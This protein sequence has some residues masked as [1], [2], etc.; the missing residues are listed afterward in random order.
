MKGQPRQNSEREYRTFNVTSLGVE[1]RTE[2]DRQKIVGHAA[3]FDTIGDGGWFREK[4]APGAF[5]LSIENDDIR[6]LFNHD[7]NFVL[8][9]NKAG[10]LEL[11]E[12]DK[13]LWVGIDPPDTQ[14]A[15]DLVKSIGR[16]DITQ[17]S[18]GFEILKEERVS[19]EGKDP[20][21]FILKEVRLWDVSPVTFPFYKQT[22]VSVHSR[23][24]WADAQNAARSFES[25][26]WK[27][28]L[29]RKKLD[30]T[31]RRI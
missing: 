2:G 31:Q 3:V 18:F 17:M 11:R 7:P 16:G 19:G 5:T 29:L 24:A 8:G 25:K 9:R 30:L 28:G 1:K 22:D 12:D 14:F 20:A 10:T 13:G 23:E 4:V 27:V 6:A 21:L 26:G 15:S